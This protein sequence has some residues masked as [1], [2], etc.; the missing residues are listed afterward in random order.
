MAIKEEDF[1]ETFEISS[2]AYAMYQALKDL[3][4]NNADYFQH[5][6]TENGQRLHSGFLALIDHVNNVAPLVDDVRKASSKFDLDTETPGNGYRS[7]V[8]VVDMCVV[9]GVKL[10]RQ[11]CESRDSFLFRKSHYAREVEACSQVM[12]SLGSCLRL[13]TTMLSWSSPGELFCEEK[14]SAEELLKHAETINMYCF[15]GRCLGFQ[16]CESIQ[17]ILKTISILMASFSEMY[18]SDAGLFVKATNSVWTGGKYLLNPELRARRIVNVSQ[19]ASVGFCKSFWLLSEMEFLG[20]LPG[21]VGPSLAV[22]QVISIPPEP[23]EHIAHDGSKVSIPLPTA[24]IGRAPIEVRLLSIVR[25][26]GMKIGE[27]KEKKVTIHRPSPV[28]II[29][30]HGGGFV[31]QSSRSHEVYLREWASHLKVP[32]LSVD[33]SLAPQA[34]FPRA[35]EEV[36]YA[37]CWAINNCHILGSTAE[38]ILLVGDSAG[39]NLNV[40]VTM[41]CIELGLRIPD[42]LFLAYIPVLVSFVPSPSRLLCFM[43]PL[44]PF[45]FM[46]RCL[47]A[48]ACPIVNCES[49]MDDISESTLPSSK[50]PDRRKEGSLI[51]Q[52]TGSDT[53]SFEEVSE[54]DLLELAA[55]KS[56]LSEEGTDTLTTVSLTSLQ[57]KPEADQAFKSLDNS[58]MKTE[59]DRANDNRSE[60]YVSEFLEKYVLDSDTDS[61]GRKVPVLRTERTNGEDSEEQVLFEMPQELG[62]SAKFGKAMGNFAS[63]MSN[64]FGFITGRK[65][66]VS[67]DVVEVGSRKQDGKSL[68]SLSPGMSLLTSDLDTLLQRSPSDEFQFEVPKDPYLSPYWASDSVLRQFPPVSI[69]SV[70]LD[71]CLDDCVMFARKLKRLG[72]CVTLD[73]LDGLPHG[74]LSFSAFSKEAHSGSMLCVKRIQELI[75]LDG[76]SC[77]ED[78]AYS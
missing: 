47:K 42:G 17:Q 29:H 27:G 28:L 12:A 3:C 37:Y 9:H 73:V 13:L 77:S 5:D 55:H 10:S 32:I 14:H 53:E 26:E 65:S 70:Q 78:D 69:L 40:G 39:A 43:D 67:S 41:K 7:F 6:D 62:L 71:P 31:A 35:L 36:L 16:F 21:M 59:A 61:E 30:C 48:Y 25:R 11:V 1:S 57:S 33:Y 63:G 64:T 4:L 18:Y 76:N 66:P 23:L 49:E 45:G 72:I 44:L 51:S 24:H 34:P 15:Y 52:R 50:L 19:C 22:N 60:H 38:K 56:P 58:L 20:H 68:S 54:S 8:S 74:F 46:M 2:P 75:N